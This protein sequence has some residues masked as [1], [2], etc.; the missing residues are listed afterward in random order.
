MG[1][2]AE[3]EFSKELTMDNFASLQLQM[4]T[5]EMYYS[6]QSCTYHLESKVAHNIVCYTWKFS[7]DKNFTN[8]MAA[9]FVFRGTNFHQCGKRHRILYAIVNTQQKLAC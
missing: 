3:L 8:P 6:Q 2:T 1:Q 4:C 9:T 5:S 7:L